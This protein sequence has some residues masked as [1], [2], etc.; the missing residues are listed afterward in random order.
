MTHEVD[1]EMPPQPG[2]LI[3]GNGQWYMLVDARP[4]RRKTDGASSHLLTWRS[5]C[6]KCGH[7]FLVDSGLRRNKLPRHCKEHR[8]KGPAKWG[9]DALDLLQSHTLTGVW[10]GPRE[11]E[12]IPKQP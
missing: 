10:N 3:R 11:N 1:F 9:A 4:Y 7:P 8:K 6:R 2:H 5:H 12:L